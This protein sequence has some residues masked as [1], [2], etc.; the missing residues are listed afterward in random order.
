MGP[1]SSGKST[2]MNHL[3]NTRFFEMDA[4]SRR[5][6]TTQARPPRDALPNTR[7][8]HPA[9]RATP[10]AQ[11]RLPNNKSLVLF[12]SKHCQAVL[13]PLAS[14]GPPPT[15]PG[16][17]DRQVHQGG[18]Q[19][20]RHGSRGALRARGEDFVDLSAPAEAAAEEAKSFAF[21][22]PCSDPTRLAFSATS[23][24]VSHAA[25]APRISFISS[26][27]CHATQD[28]TTHSSLTLCPRTLRTRSPQGTDGRE[29]GEDDTAFEKQSALFAMAARHLKTTRTVP[30]AHAIPPQS[31][32]VTQ[33]ML[34]CVRCFSGGGRAPGQ[35]VV[36]RHRPRVRGR[37]APAQDSVPGA[38]RCSR[39][40]FA[41]TAS[42]IR[43]H[44]I[45]D[46]CC[47]VSLAP[48]CARADSQPAET[49]ALCHVP[50]G[51]LTP[52][53]LPNHHAPNRGPIICAKSSFHR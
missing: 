51:Q 44:W 42:R 43:A 50:V 15:C 53:T 6:Q 40:G 7:S 2:L 28:T 31:P 34:P 32:R 24:S 49:A 17:V 30:I 41:P 36:P 13:A 25:A 8:G 18:R 29:R 9:L 12:D 14:R 16:R 19:D 37:E 23:R 10:S 45:R 33:H 39:V 26:S 46:L 52:P 35:H 21:S 38:W 48:A 3:F 20:H 22:P 11:P 27:S 1:Q 47:C 5:G 4:L